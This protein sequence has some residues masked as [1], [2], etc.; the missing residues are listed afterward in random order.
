MTDTGWL[1]CI[2]FGDTIYGGTVEWLRTDRLS[3]C[4]QSGMYADLAKND[5]T[6]WG[7]GDDYECGIPVDATIIGVLVFIRKKSTD[8]ADR[9][10]DVHVSLKLNATT[11]AGQNYAKG[12]NWP[13]SWTD[14]EYG[15]ETNKWGLALTPTNVNSEFFGAGISCNNSA[16]DDRP[17][18][19]CIRV[20][21]FY[22]LGFTNIAKINGIPVADIVKINGILL[23]DIEKM[24][25]VT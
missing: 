10:T 16:G 22:E 13:T 14:Y 25:G 21:V 23:I 15:G 2:Q 18:V 12:G 24:N 17:T 5:L 1:N 7:Y 19:D 9:I 3:T 11:R 6:W 20:K 4:Q 8:H